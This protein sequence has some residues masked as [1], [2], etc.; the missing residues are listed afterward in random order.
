MTPQRGHANP[1]C[2]SGGGVQQQS[3]EKL[4]RAVGQGFIPGMESAEL[5]RALLVA[6][7]NNVLSSAPEARCLLAPL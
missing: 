1:V 3:A 5:A 2:F 6:A 4:V 7:K